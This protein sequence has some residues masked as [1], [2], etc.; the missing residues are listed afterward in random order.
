M[1]VAGGPKIETD[2]LV[3]YYDVDNIDSYPGEPTTNYCYIGGSWGGD[4]SSQAVGTK[5]SVEITDPNLMY[6]GYRTV[7]W[8]PGTSRNCYLN[9]SNDF[10]LSATSTQ[11]AFSCYIKRDDGAV[12]S[13]MSSYMYYPSSDGSAGCTVTS[14]GNGWYRI[15]RL[16]TG[17]SNVLSLI[18]FTSMASEHKYYLSGWQL[19]KKTH[20]TQYAG[21]S[22]TRPS[23]NGLKDLSGQ[24]NHADLSNA[25]FDSNALIDYDNATKLNVGQVLNTSGTSEFSICAWWKT[26]SVSGWHTV[27]GTNVSYAQIGMLNTS[28]YAGRNSGGGWWLSTTGLTTTDWN[29]SVFTYSGTTANFYVNGQLVSGPYVGAF[30]GSHGDT[31]ISSYNSTGG[32]FFDGKIPLIRIYTR[33]LTSKEILDNYNA[34]KSRFGK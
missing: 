3:L 5:G 7:L 26:D 16:R 31:M 11:W 34:Q 22:A 10:D 32:E 4:G 15:S 14:V 19:E 8:T 6:N 20:L 12:I 2:G 25:T 9:G 28:L 24:A 13:S 27:V 1:T 29:Y 30:A 21:L 33:E 17:T 23:A 18:G